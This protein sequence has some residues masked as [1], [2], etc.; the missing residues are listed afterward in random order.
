MA[1]TA[2]RYGP[3]CS[4]ESRNYDTVTLNPRRSGSVGPLLL[5]PA[6][7]HGP[8]ALPQSD[9]RRRPM[10][11]AAAST[12]AASVLASLVATTEIIRWRAFTSMVTGL[13]A[14]SVLIRGSKMKYAA[15][16]LVF[17]SA[18]QTP[19]LRLVQESSEQCVVRCD[20]GFDGCIRSCPRSNAKCDADCRTQLSACTSKCVK[21]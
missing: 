20:R 6:L 16:C 4:P 21:R 12:R 5:P 17:L 10:P 13:K 11:S 14:E 19:K 8:R 18:A 3:V 15:V 2:M 7:M 9:V 1:A